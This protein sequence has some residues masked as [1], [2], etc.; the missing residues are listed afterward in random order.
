VTK[1]ETLRPF[2]FDLALSSAIW[3]GKY[4]GELVAM[5]ENVLGYEPESK[6]EEFDEKK[7]NA[8]IS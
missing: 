1:S 4:L 2:T 5:C 6:G 7:Q 3:N 8:K